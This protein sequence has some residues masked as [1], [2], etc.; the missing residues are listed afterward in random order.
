MFI[1]ISLVLKLTVD[2]FFAGRFR[3][4]YIVAW[5]ADV[6]FNLEILEFHKRSALSLHQST[7]KR[8]T[9]KFHQKPKTN[10]R[11]CIYA[12]AKH[13]L[14]P[15]KAYVTARVSN[16]IIVSNEITDSVEDKDTGDHKCIC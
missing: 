12:A 6:T 11:C 3:T 7:F 14:R 2:V 5:T 15:I 9:V 16:E 10:A 1:T 4:A 13:N 8:F